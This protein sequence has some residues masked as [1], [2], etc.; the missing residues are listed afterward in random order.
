MSRSCYPVKI[1]PRNANSWSILGRFA[2]GV[3]E[4]SALIEIQLARLER[5]LVLVR[6]R[7][8]TRQGKGEFRVT[9][10]RMSEERGEDGGKGDAI[11]L[12]RL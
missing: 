11:F 4:I 12:D 2:K 3:S 7:N 6:A 9:A 5:M 10:V 1:Y 8:K